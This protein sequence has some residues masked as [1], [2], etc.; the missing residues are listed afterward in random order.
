MNPTTQENAF[1][2]LASP[3][4]FRTKLSV[5]EEEMASKIYRAPD[6]DV[7]LTFQSGDKLSGEGQYSEQINLTVSSIKI[8]EG[9]S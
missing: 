2:K 7:M 1:G 9:T 6:H 8:I 4:F 3:G 5:R